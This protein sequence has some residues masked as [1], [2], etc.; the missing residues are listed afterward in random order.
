M[1]Q[2]DADT[3]EFLE[4]LDPSTR[5]SYASGISAFQTFYRAQGTIKDFLDRV[6]EDA[7]KPRRERGRIARNTL[8]AFMEWLQDNERNYKPKTVR[9]YVAAI[10]SEAKYFDIAIST[11]YVNLPAGKPFSQKYPWTLE[12]VA[13]F[14]QKLKHPTYETMAV[15]IFQSGLSLSDLLALTYGDIQHEFETGVTPLCLDLSRI[16]TDVPFMTFIG[17]WGVSLLK[18][19]LAGRTL[20]PQ[21]PL[22]VKAERSIEDYFA[23]LARN[24][25]GEYKGRNPM[26]PHSLRSAFQTMLSDHQVNQL[27][28]DFW[29]GHKV[30][31][32]KGV[33]ISKSREGWRETYK[34]QAEPWL[35]PRE[36]GI[37]NAC[38]DR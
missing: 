29:M 26:R 13:R 34:T 15:V 31:E 6:E 4:A 1:K 35:T 20:N 38:E 28:I 14:V 36:A 16:K 23:R 2:F 24:M 21:L 19:H 30:P 22:F 8:K 12:E 9:A 25:L 33:Y 32:Q 11:R 3:I 5:K 7:S 27:Y 37:V 18:Q 10:Q 17:E